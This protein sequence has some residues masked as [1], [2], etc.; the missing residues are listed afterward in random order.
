[1]PRQRDA[2]HHGD[3]RSALVRAALKALAKNGELP[4]WRALALACG[5]SQSAPYRHFESYEDLQAAVATECFRALTAAVETA[6]TKATKPMD[7]LALGM[8]AYVA[9]GRENPAF[10]ALMFPRALSTEETELASRRAFGTLVEGVTE[11]GASEPIL[12]AQTLW[13]ALHGTVDLLR[14]GLPPEEEGGGGALLDRVIEMCIDHVEAE[15]QKK[16]PRRAH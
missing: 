14:I 6:I 16:R 11:C 5:V 4:S 10:Y 9:F 13:T 8:R 15:T 1:M 2:Y 3:L 12:L 7:R